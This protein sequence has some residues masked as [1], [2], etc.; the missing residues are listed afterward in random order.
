VEPEASAARNQAVRKSIL[1]NIKITLLGDLFLGGDYIEAVRSES[2]N[3]L[4]AFRHILPY[5]SGT[6]ILFVNL[7]GPIV[8]GGNVRPNVYSVLSNSVD[9]LELLSHG[10]ICVI[11]LANNHIMDFGPE[12]LYKTQSTLSSRGINVFGAGKDIDEAKKAV[13]IEHGNRNIAFLGFTSS[14]RHINAVI[15]ENNKPGC[16][17]YHDVNEIVTRIREL[18]KK[19]DI[20][21]V[22]LHWGYEYYLYPSPD[23][24][25]MAHTLVDAGANII[26][27]HH[28]HVIQ[29]V[30]NYKNSLIVYSLGNIFFPSFR[31]VTGRTHYPKNIT[32]EFMITTVKVNSNLKFEFELTGG[33]LDSEYSLKPYLRDTGKAFLLKMDRLSRVISNSDYERFWKQ[34]R[35]SRDRELIREGMREAM[36]KLHR[37]P[38]KELIKD[39]R[40]SDVRR[41]I[42]RLVKMFS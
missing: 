40:F 42:T 20:I 11:N 19:S 16:A 15:A 14:E 36:L 37:M 22:S 2:G 18:R 9:V 29:G 35:E 23:Q 24:V 3:P 34:Y 10:K 13:I 5:L 33:T 4:A 21:C 25:R 26:I 30:E 7:E 6:D 1:D 39:I 32:K 12:G 17:T 27:G 31:M 41:N 38:F 28:P 8:E